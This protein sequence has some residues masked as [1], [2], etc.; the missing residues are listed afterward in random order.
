MGMLTRG[1]VVLALELSGAVAMVVGGTPAA[2]SAGCT[3]TFGAQSGSRA[4]LPGGTR[5]FSADPS[6]GVWMGADGFVTDV[7]VSLSVDAGYSYDMADLEVR[8]VHQ[9]AWSAL[10]RRQQLPGGF[11]SLTLDDEGSPRSWR[12]WPMTGTVQPDEPLARHDH[13][14]VQWS[15]EVEIRNWGGEVIYAQDIRITITS[16]SC[17]SDG[18]GVPERIDN[19]PTVANRD[20]ADWDGDGLGNVCDPTPGTDPHAPPPAPPTSPPTTQ[21]TTSPTTPPTTTTSSLPPSSSGCSAA[22]GY[23]RTLE[24]K[25]QVRKHRLTGSVA[26]VAAGCRASVPVSIWKK[27]SGADRKLVVVTTRTSGTFRTTAPRKPGRYYATVGSVAEP[28][29]AEARSRTVRVRR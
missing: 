1:S 20:Q 11:Y 28:I 10:I 16:D 12:S 6:S 26:S 2:A 25:H 15:W 22:C 7:D 9:G 8:L 4:V 29:C 3:E 13:S 24:L 17:D 23:A 21:P 27:R 5:T 14:P 19:C 18:D